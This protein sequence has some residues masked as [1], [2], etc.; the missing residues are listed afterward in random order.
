VD[1]NLFIVPLDNQHIWYR[2]HALFADLLRKRLQSTQA[3]I[4]DALHHRASQW[5]EKNGQIDLAIEHAIAAH[6]DERAARLIEQVAENL[7]KLGEARIVLRWLDAIPEEKI[8][9]R[10]FLVSLY[11]FALILCGR[12]TQGVA[13]LLE[14]MKDTGSQDEFQGEIT[15]LQAFLAIM[16]GD[17][18]RTIQLSEQ[19]IQRLGVRRSFFRSLAADT[20]GM[21]YT[22]AGDIPAA[23]R[24]FERVVDISMQSDNAMMT[25]MALTNLAGLQYFHGQLQIAKTTC[26]QV[27]TLAE[28]RFGPG[29]PIIG[30]TMLNLAEILR[31]QGELETADQYFRD[32]A[33]LM[34]NFVEIG[35]PIA[36]ISLARLKMDQKEWSSAQ[37]YIDQARH[38]ALETHSTKMDDQ[39]VEIAQV[40]LWIGRGELAQALQWAEQRG[41]L[42]RSPAELLSAAG[43][44]V[45]LNELFEVE[46]LILI[47]LRLALEQPAEAVE[48][49][50]TLIRVNEQQNYNR[51]R[52]ELLILKALA[53]HQMNQMDQALNILGQALRIGEPEGYH[54]TFVEHGEPMARLLYQAVERNISPAYASR[55]LKAITEESLNISLK[56]N[57]EHNLIEPLSDRELEV[58][59]LI[60]EGLTNSEIARRLYISMSTVK[61]H[62]TNIFGKLSVRNRTQAVARAR[63]LGLLPNE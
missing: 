51:R 50:D 58:L 27:L 32:T 31:E 30:K 37:E 10:P 14:K 22:L 56:D 7:L 36:Y 34:E 6:D 43:R 60:A 48:L 3:D 15:M 38:L 40:R 26:K 29:S 18:A 42:E 11:G 21:G 5:Y 47:R 33:R 52:V 54:S 49:I 8:I 35:L 53:L 13:S 46:I 24:A 55:L 9:S 62:T 2:Y 63:R 12:S 39:L 28:E 57:R 20:L 45:A 4:L 61:G 1:T 25:I 16:H 23:T 17:A 44:N 19:A 41:L 59:G